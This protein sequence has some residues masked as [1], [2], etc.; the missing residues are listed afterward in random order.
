MNLKANF[1]AVPISLA[2]VA[3]ISVILG[4]C[5]LNWVYFVIGAMVG[6]LNHG[7]MVKQNARTYRFAQMDPEHKVFKPKKS[8]VLWYVLR[9]VVFLGVFAA[10]IVKSN[11]KENPNAVWEIVIALSGYLLTKVGFIVCLMLFKEKKEDKEN[12][13]EKKVIEN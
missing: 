10:L 1:L 7:L 2:V 12:K 8:A 9:C 3:I 6:L 11:P 4:L 13:E 5:G